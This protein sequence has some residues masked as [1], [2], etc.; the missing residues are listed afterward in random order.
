M[1]GTRFGRPRGRFFSV[2]AEQ[3]RM[4]RDLEQYQ[5]VYGTEVAWYFLLAVGAGTIM[6]DIYD[7]GEVTG[8]KAYDG[9]HRVPVLAAQ[10]RQGQDEADDQGLA[11][12]DQVTLKLSFEQARRAGLE[13]DL[14]ANREQHIHDRFVW[15]RRVFD[16]T[17]IQT[18]GHFDQTSRDVT[19]V[20]N[21]VQVRS[22]EIID[23]PIFQEYFMQ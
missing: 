13:V 17:G 1:P 18:A 10:V 20:V 8:G 3:R 21:A 2:R 11:T 19:I 23:S 12:W 5:Q 7:E 6:N 4:D 15:R 22:D 14:I 16:V 9:P